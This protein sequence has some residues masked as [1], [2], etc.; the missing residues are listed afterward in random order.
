MGKILFFALLAMVLSSG[1]IYAAVCHEKRYEQILPINFT[2]IV[3]TLMVFGLFNMLELGFYAVLAAAAVLWLLAGKAFFA[4]LKRGR[5][6]IYPVLSRIMSPGMWVFGFMALALI[7]VDYGRVP[8]AYDEFSHWADAAKVMVFYNDFVTNPAAATNF[9]SYPPGMTLIQYFVEKLYIL[10][11]NSYVDWLLYYSYQLFLISFILP[12]VADKENR[13]PLNTLLRAAVLLLVPCLM[14]DF[15]TFAYSTTLIDPFLSVVLG[16]A[17]GLIFTR[18]KK[19]GWCC[20]YICC[21]AFMLVLSKAAGLLLG[22]F[23]LFAFVLVEF[24]SS[25]NKKQAAGRSALLGFAVLLPFLL[26]RIERKTSAISQS[27]SSK[28][29]EVSLSLI[30]RLITHTEDS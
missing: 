13:K 19:D 6:E 8:M 3:L 20:A 28:S 4:K 21:A 9:P 14:Y 5:D 10:S 23:V 18:E 29:G 25:E 12:F 7:F 22:A 16:C 27:F 15:D 17:L 30:F 11:G 2:A 26:W 1:S 24:R